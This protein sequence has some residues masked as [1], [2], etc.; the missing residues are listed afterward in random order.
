MLPAAAY[1]DTAV[2]D[3]ERRHLFDAGWICVGRTDLPHV[4]SQR[5]VAIGNT[6]ALMV[7]SD[8]RTVRG[9]FNVCGHRAHELLQT[10][11]EACAQVVRCPYHA[12]TYDLEGAL[13]RA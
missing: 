2:L 9:F 1:T 7:R 8:E 13:R 11:Q 4:G 10:G 3:W 6:T 12:W 5:A